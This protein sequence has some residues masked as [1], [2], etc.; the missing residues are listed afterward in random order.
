ML[1]DLPAEVHVGEFAGVGMSPGHCHRIGDFEAFGVGVLNEKT[2]C[3]ADIA[4]TLLP[5]LFHL[6]LKETEI[7]LLREDLESLCGERRSHDYL[8]EDGFHLK[9]HFGCHFAVEC[10]YAAVDADFVSLVGTGPRVEH[11]R[12]DSSTAGVHVLESDT[13]RLAEFAHDLKSGVGVLNIVVRQFFA[14]K[15]TRSGHAV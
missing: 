10:H 7:L 11:I 5:F 4:G 15:L 3:H 14:L 1:H 9:S 2:A 13:E 6:H 8:K 12:P